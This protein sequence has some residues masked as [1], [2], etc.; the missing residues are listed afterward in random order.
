[1]LFSNL[2]LHSKLLEVLAQAGYTEATTVQSQSIPLGLDGHDLMVSAATGSGKTAAFLLPVLQKMLLLQES[3]PNLYT[4]N[5]LNSNNQNERLGRDGRP[6]R[7]AFG[8]NNA[9]NPNRP[10]AS[11]L[12]LCPTRELAQQVADAAMK[13]GRAITGFKVA[14]VVGGVPYGAQLAQLKSRPNIIVATP[15]RLIDHL[16]SKS[17]NLSNISTLV[18]DEADRMLDMGFI[19]DIEHIASN[20]TTDR[21]TVL[22]SAT[23]AGNVGDLAKKLTRDPKRIDVASHT[24]KH[25]NIIQIL[26]W[27]DSAQ[28]KYDLLDNILCRVELDQAIVFTSTQRDADWLAD[29]LYDAGHSAAALHGGMPQGRRTRVLNGLRK[30]DL[31]ILIATD[32]AARGIDIP[33]ISHVINFGLPMTAEDYVHRI[34]RTGRAGKTGTALTLAVADEA[35]K[36]R[37]IQR[38]TTQIIPVDIII[39]LEP[40]KPAPSLERPSGKRGTDKKGYGNFENRS[41]RNH[42]QQD[43]RKYSVHTK[44]RS[45]SNGLGRTIKHGSTN[46]SNP[47]VSHD[48][49]QTR[50]SQEYNDFNKQKPHNQFQTANSFIVNPNHNTDFNKKSHIFIKEQGREGLDGRSKRFAKR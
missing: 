6:I 26:H 15:G 27:A 22:F 3:N 8:R 16:N 2:N 21:Q 9:I 20:L 46:Y 25:D 38:F 31:R 13:Y 5:N 14:T 40:K 11:V 39:G 44:E 7:G 45:M 18:L 30:K 37:T 4:Q 49:M 41:R 50:S 29:K 28:H 10:Q 42:N 47:F 23:F 12:V 19:E 43:G 1:M 48:T 33:S 35:H 34:G 36:I 24:D 32:V 17:V